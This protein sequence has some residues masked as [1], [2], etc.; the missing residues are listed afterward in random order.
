MQH[1]VNSIQHALT[2]DIPLPFSVYTSVKEQVLR[3][4]PIAKPLFI[5]VLSGSKTLGPKDK[6]TCP[7]GEFIFLPASSSI[8]MRNIPANSNYLALLIEFEHA[9]FDGLQVNAVS[10]NDHYIGRACPTLNHCLHQF[11]EASLWASPTILS[12]RKRE[13]LTLLAE[14]GHGEILGLLATPRLTDQIHDMFIAAEQFELT[15]QQI[16][17][18]LAMSESTLRRKL[19]LEAS[20]VQEI[21]D[22]ARLGL[23]LH[24]LQTTRLPM[25]AIS[26]KCGYQ[27]PSRFT[28]RFKRHFGLTPS[29]LRKTQLI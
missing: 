26:E 11:V 4:V 12:L 16:C 25:G 17:S 18:A 22:N 20:S 3:N 5:M 14:L 10:E 27:S 24:L 9:D 1:L 2:R 28:D 6:I 8:N 7:F 13:L 23:A 21:K 19:K 29:A 15:N